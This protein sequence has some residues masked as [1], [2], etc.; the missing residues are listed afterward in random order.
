[1]SKKIIPPKST[2]KSAID[3]ICDGIRIYALEEEAEKASMREEITVLRA[4]VSC[5]KNDVKRLQGGA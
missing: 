3:L 2:D 1:M 4:A 5:L